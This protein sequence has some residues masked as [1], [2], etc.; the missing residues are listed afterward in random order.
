MKEAVGKKV[1]AGARVVLAVAF[2]AAAA[3]AAHAG[4]FDGLTKKS[5]ADAAKAAGVTE[6]ADAVRIPLKALDSGKALFLAM[7][8]GG[9][10]F[11]YFALRSGDGKYRSALDAC[12]VCF[13]AN[14]GYRQEADRMVCN[15]CGMKFAADKIGEKKGGCNPHPLAHREEAGFM[16]IAKSDIAAGKD[17]FPGKRK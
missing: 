6:T 14:L 9:R 17:Y 10:Q 1:S 4:V 3:A 11:H 13:R 2:L 7:E 8:S 15:N 5:P 12:D 16:V